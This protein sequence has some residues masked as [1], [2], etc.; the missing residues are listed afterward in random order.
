VRT[1]TAV[2]LAVFGVWLLLRRRTDA[3]RVVVAW[4]DGSE[5]ELEPGSPG[6]DRLVAVAQEALR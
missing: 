2:V 5:L 6:R 4:G 1:A 3:E